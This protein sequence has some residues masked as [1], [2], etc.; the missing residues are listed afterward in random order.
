MGVVVK[1]PEPVVG[2]IACPAAIG[3]VGREAQRRARHRLAGE[4]REHR[5]AIGRAKIAGRRKPRH[6]GN[7]DL[8]TVG[9][10]EVMQRAVIGPVAGR[11]GV[12]DQG[13]R[14]GA[15]NGLEHHRE[16]LA[17]TAGDQRIG[18]RRDGRGHRCGLGHEMQRGRA[19]RAVK[20]LHRLVI[21]DR[22]GR[23]DVL[24]GGKQPLRLRLA[25]D[26]DDM[27]DAEAR[28]GLRADGGGGLQPHLHPVP[29]RAAGRGDRRGPVAIG[30]GRRDIGP[31]GGTRAPVIGRKGPR[32]NDLRR[33]AGAKDRDGGA[34]LAKRRAAVEQGPVAGETGD[35]NRAGRDGRGSVP[36]APQDRKR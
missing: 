36:L 34:V 9:G 24:K 7:A 14:V 3:D 6:R 28:R 17:R 32:L 25:P 30:I 13:A 26:G 19:C 16:F 8:L 5:L 33:R 21:G 12:I 22:G 20:D 29:G 2:V 23:R 18:Q 15:G 27:A 4:K 10:G 11:V 31:G 1:F 35:G